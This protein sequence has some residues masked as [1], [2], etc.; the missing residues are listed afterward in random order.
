MMRPLTSLVHQSLRA[1]LRSRLVAALLALLAVVVLV[2]PRTVK[3]DGTPEGDLRMLLTWTLG[4]AVFVLAAATLWAGCHALAGEVRDGTLGRLAV[5]PARRFE[6]FLG[7]WLGL[8]ILNAGLLAAALA[9]VALQVAQRGIPLALLRPYRTVRV[10]EESLRE[11]AHAI[12]V[13]ARAEGRIPPGE[14]EDA[15]LER[16]RGEL[17]EVHL[18]VS[19]GE[20]HLWRFRLPA[21]A[22]RAGEP[23]RMR[24]VFTTPIGT[25]GEVSAGCRVLNAAGAELA[26]AEI[27]PEHRRQFELTIDADRVGATP[28]LALLLENTADADGMA[29]LVGAETGATLLVPQ[30]S[31]G[32]NFLAAGVVLWSV[33]AALAALGLAAGALFSLPVAVFAASSLTVIVLVSHADL[34]AWGRQ[35]SADD[36][37]AGAARLERLSVAVLRRVAVLTR[38]AEEAAPLDRLGERLLVTPVE[39]LRAAGSVGLLLPLLAG[40]VAVPVLRQREY[41]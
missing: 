36:R 15:W 26:T 3:G 17:R 29:L 10:S 19:P 8:V 20:A 23:L 22:L 40:L 14:T 30:G 32:G 25:A 39:A 38:A 11:H 4:A 16:L 21:R 2:L 35:D 9:G 6:L 1:A 33:L 24:V 31:V 18:P 27:G 5:T 12:L 13:R 37:P 41:P 34:D 7:K 28:T